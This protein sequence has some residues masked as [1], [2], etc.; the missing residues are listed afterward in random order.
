MKILF[1]ERGK[2]WSHGLPDGFRDIGHQVRISGPVTRRMLTRLLPSFKPDLLISVGWGPDHTHSK[3]RLMRELATRYKIPL[4]Y[5][6]TEDPNFTDVFTLPL[7]KRVKPDY[8]FTIS[9]KTA[10]RFRKLGYPAAH[11]DFAYHPRIHHRTKTIKKYETDIAVVAN[12]YPDV[13][14]KYP[15]HYRN[16]SIRILLR[17]LLQNGYRIDFYG[18]NWS[19]M[20]A[21]LGRQIPNKSIRGYLPYKNANKVFSSAKIIIGLQ[22]YPDM[23]TQRTYETIG[24]EG[25]F[26][27]CNTPA[28]RALL[29]PGRDVEVSSSSAETLKKVRYYLNNP[30]ERERI[31][32]NGRRAIANHNYTSRARFVLQTLRRNGVIK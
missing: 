32:K 30:K 23:L 26:L 13:L 27:T 20:K 19:R 14:K 15:K 22:N 17:P 16:E 6:S 8:T 18:R 11:L 29:R 31:R 21:I 10:A 7:L 24:S 4:V 12:A 3:Q 25:F 2:L 5:W 9:S 28:V 1:L